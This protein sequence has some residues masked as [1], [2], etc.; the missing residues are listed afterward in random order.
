MRDVD[1]EVEDDAERAVDR[2]VLDSLTG[3]REGTGSD[4]NPP[5]RAGEAPRTRE[6]AWLPLRDKDDD[7]DA[8]L[9]V[10]APPPPP[11][12]LRS[13]RADRS[14][15]ASAAAGRGRE[16]P[17]AGRA[18]GDGLPRRAD[19]DGD[20]WRSCDGCGL[21]SPLPG[22]CGLRSPLPAGCDDDDEAAAAEEEEHGA[23]SGDD[24]SRPAARLGLATTFRAACCQRCVGDVE[25]V[26]PPLV[27]AAASVEE[28]VEP[29]ADSRH[30]ELHSELRQGDV[31]TD[32]GGCC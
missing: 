6:G 14:S 29:P 10:G 24:P 25:D 31:T 26:A 18:S 5:L 23:A 22:G 13:L 15:F 20:G 32:R 12:S 16:E 11:P 27:S 30:G 9:G 7:D 3:E 2:L 1:R 28:E 21:R 8:L 4:A 17:A 19:L